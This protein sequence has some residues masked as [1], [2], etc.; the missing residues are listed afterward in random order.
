ML[1]M[2]VGGGRQAALDEMLR[3]AVGRLMKGPLVL[4]WSPPNMYFEVPAVSS[5]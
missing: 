3:T 5:S 1:E 4:R 2:P